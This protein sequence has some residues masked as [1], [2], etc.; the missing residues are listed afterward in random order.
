M[1][2][3]TALEDGKSYLKQVIKIKKMKMITNREEYY[4][5]KAIDFQKNVVNVRNCTTSTTDALVWTYRTT[6]CD[7]ISIITTTVPVRDGHMK[8][9]KIESHEPKR[10]P[11]IFSS[12]L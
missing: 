2:I 8:D 12:S 1:Y 9:I 11:F 10:Y 6:N 4:R 3:E 5:Q 7:V